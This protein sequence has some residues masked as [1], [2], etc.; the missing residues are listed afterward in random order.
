MEEA[1]LWN[2]NGLAAVREEEEGSWCC[3]LERERAGDDVLVLPDLSDPD[4]RRERV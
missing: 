3:E 4:E 2:C 1:L